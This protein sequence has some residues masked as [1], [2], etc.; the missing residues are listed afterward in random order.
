LMDKTELL[1][2]ALSQRVDDVEDQATRSAIITGIVMGLLGLLAGALLLPV[3][4]HFL[5]GGS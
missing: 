3:V 4:S 1:I 2:K 5:M